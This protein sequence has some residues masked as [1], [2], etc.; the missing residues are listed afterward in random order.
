MNYKVTMREITEYTSIKDKTVLL[1]LQEELGIRKIYSQVVTEVLSPDQ[2]QMRVELCEDFI[3]A[4][5]ESGILNRVV[6]GDE[7]CIYEYDPCNK[8][9]QWNRKHKRNYAQR[10]HACSNQR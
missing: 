1:I 9:H 4:D 2:K 5:A 8:R 3:V 7:S 6:T 10:R